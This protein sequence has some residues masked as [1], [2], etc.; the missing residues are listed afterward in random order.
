M[1]LDR[2]A[3]QSLLA[4]YHHNPEKLDNDINQLKEK[5][6]HESCDLVSLQTLCCLL[7]FARRHD[8]MSQIYH[9]HIYP[10]LNL[11]ESEPLPPTEKVS[12]K[13][14]LVIYFFGRSGSMFFATLFDSHPQVIGPALGFEYVP[15]LLS[16]CRSQSYTTFLSMLAVPSNHVFNIDLLF[17]DNPVHVDRYRF[18]NTVHTIICTKGW[19]KNDWV[20]PH[21]LFLALNLAYMIV[22]GIK[23]N[24]SPCT[25]L[26]H[27]HQYKPERHHFIQDNFSNPTFMFIV[28]SP[29]ETMA[30]HY[31]QTAKNSLHAPGRMAS[32]NSFGIN[33]FSTYRSNFSKD[34][35]C[36]IKLEDIKQTPKKTLSDICR[37][38][39]LPYHSCLLQ[40]TIA[41][42]EFAFRG[43]LGAVKGFAQKHLKQS[44]RKEFSRLDEFRIRTLLLSQYHN[45]RYKRTNG[46]FSFLISMFT[47]PFF[48]LPFRLEIFQFRLNVSQNGRQKAIG[49]FLFEYCKLRK[50]FY[51]KISRDCLSPNAPVPLFSPENL[52]ET[53]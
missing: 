31:I 20:A 4:E 47:L 38:L 24:N 12:V 34:N 51:K 25:L 16:K 13:N 2:N 44:Y 45:W 30:S 5:A 17:E 40:S 53:K 22:K 14:V 32:A 26:F 23:F 46:L 15:W 19:I 28:R 42:K 37:F 3:I 18:I 49:D 52:S 7:N 10:K 41:G 50:L 11:R 29:F 43:R 35:V 39:D 6:N 36:A 9:Q 21:N 48:L 8:E 33:L 1:Q 27:A